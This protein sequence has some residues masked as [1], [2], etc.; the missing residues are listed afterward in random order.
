MDEDV[1]NLSIRKFLKHFGVTAQREIERAVRAAIED[2]TLSGRETLPIRAKLEID[3]VVID[4][5][6]DGELAL[7]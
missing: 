1:F 3:G 4:F 7:A 6:I 2:G 5:S